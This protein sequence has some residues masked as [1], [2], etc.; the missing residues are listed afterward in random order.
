MFKN[1]FFGKPDFVFGRC[2]KNLQKTVKFIIY[3]YVRLIFY[4]V[5]LVNGVL[6]MRGIYWLWVYQ[7]VCSVIFNLRVDAH[8]SIIMFR[9]FEINTIKF[10]RIAA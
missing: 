3:F 1:V 4:R 8:I 2:K 5:Y 10:T 6:R 7:Q 9:I